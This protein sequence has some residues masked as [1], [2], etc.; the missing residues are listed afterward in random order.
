M[1]R[2]RKFISQYIYNIILVGLALLLVCLV[3]FAFLN[4]FP[5]L[6]DDFVLINARRLIRSIRALYLFPLELYKGVD[7]RLLLYVI[8]TFLLYIPKAVSNVLLALLPAVIILVMHRLIYGV[9]WKNKINWGSVLL[10]AC[11]L[12][13]V[14]PAYAQVFFWITATNY[15]IAAALGLIGLMPLVRALREEAPL[16]KYR[17]PRWVLAFIFYS[18]IGISDYFIAGGVLVFCLL[19]CIYCFFAY[20][21]IYAWVLF[22]IGGLLSGLCIIITAPGNG[23]R[24]AVTAA[25]VAWFS[26]IPENLYDYCGYFAD[27]LFFM[28]VISIIYFFFLKKEKMKQSIQTSFLHYVVTDK[29]TVLASFFFITFL[30]ILCAGSLY[31]PLAKRVMTFA[32]FLLLMTLAVL[33]QRMYYNN[34][35]WMLPLA[36]LMAILCGTFVFSEFKIRISNDLIGQSRLEAI[37]ANRNANIC[38]PPYLKHNAKTNL[39]YDIVEDKKSWHNEAV[40]E[41]YTLNSVMACTIKNATCFTL[42]ND[43]ICAEQIDAR[44]A[45]SV[46]ELNLL[47]V[48]PKEIMLSNFSEGPRGIIFKNIWLL[49][50]MENATGWR[51]KLLPL[52]YSTYLLDEVTGKLPVPLDVTKSH[53]DL[54]IFLVDPETGALIKGD[55]SQGYYQVLEGGPVEPYN[56][57]Q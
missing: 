10:L 18:I 37:E 6:G 44:L 45:F 49:L 22:A 28:I 55:R 17:L 36:C 43:K 20:K 3:Q 33:L 30:S 23:Y 50:D 54:P 19:T 41:Y 39:I 7:G 26:K 42:G 4:K 46:A 9:A 31:L 51:A 29:T 2:A 8:N 12:W 13:L 24:H 34:K 56:F 40:A 21:K 48:K 57:L 47:P 15:S 27:S 11:G 38:L 52:F 14:V 16:L 53:A 32:A 5:L 25:G 35:R 1:S